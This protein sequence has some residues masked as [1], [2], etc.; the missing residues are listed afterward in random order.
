[1]TTRSRVKDISGQR[2]GRLVAEALLAPKPTGPALWQCR[3]DCGETKIVAGT[4]LRCGHTQSCGCLCRDKT[5]ERL[6]ALTGDKH[7][8]WKGGR[9]SNG[10]DGYVCVRSGREYVLEHRL[11]MEKHLGRPLTEHETVHHKNGIRDDNRI[12]NL[13]LWS[14]RHPGGQRVADLVAFAKEILGTY[15][16]DSLVERAPCAQTS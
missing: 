6:K 3:C 15:A 12:E 1:M 2:F 4:A 10:P 5:V 7:P 13:E 14:S 16:P 9:V 8:H 11:V